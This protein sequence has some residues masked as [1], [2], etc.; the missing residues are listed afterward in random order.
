MTALHSVGYLLR[1]MTPAKKQRGAIILKQCLDL[2]Q[3][4]CE[5]IM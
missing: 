4:A 5:N 3:T 2:L 1:K